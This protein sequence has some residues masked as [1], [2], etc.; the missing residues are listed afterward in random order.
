LADSFFAVVAGC[1]PSRAVLLGLPNEIAVD[2]LSRVPAD[3]LRGELKLVSRA[4]RDFV[5]DPF[6]RKSRWMR[7]RQLRPLRRSI[8]EEDLPA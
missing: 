3:S 6:H 7:R 8:R 2:I 5:A 4:W 1:G